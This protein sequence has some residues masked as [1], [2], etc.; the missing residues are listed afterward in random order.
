[1]SKKNTGSMSFADFAASGRKLNMRFFDQMNELLDW[2]VIEKV[3]SKYDKRGVAIAGN[4][5]YPGLRTFGGW[6]F[7]AT[8]LGSSSR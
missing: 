1:M 4:S 2:S 5:A 3:V 8:F 7:L 6:V